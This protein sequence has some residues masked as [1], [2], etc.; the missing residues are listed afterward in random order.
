MIMHH[1]GND[2]RFHEQA[3]INN[4]YAYT[5]DSPPNEVMDRKLSKISQYIDEAIVQ[6]Y[7]VLAYVKPY[8]KKVH[9][10][11]IAIDLKQF[12]PLFPSTMPKKPLILHAPT[13][14]AF[15]GTACIERAIEKL[16]AT[17]EFE[18]RRIE[19]MDHEQAVA[20]YKEADIIV[21]Q[22]HCGSYG[23]LSV[24]SMALGK[25]VVAYIRPDLIP[26]FPSEPPII[27]ANPDTIYEQIKMLLDN[28]EHRYERGGAGRIYAEK[29]HAID[30]IGDKLL[31]I[32]SELQR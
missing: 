12:T 29:Y 15:K 8:Y 2:V 13:N 21:D 32:Y 18:Y 24:E 20:L 23:L 19:K 17:H 10:L 22:I 4:P 16:R 6:D 27:N 11:P 14:P 26:S 5:G 3:R 9:I 31:A 30:V 25:P 28:P 1:W 7:E